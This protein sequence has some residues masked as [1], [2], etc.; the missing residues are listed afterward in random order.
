MKTKTVLSIASA[1]FLIASACNAGWL[2]QAYQGAFCA[3]DHRYVVSNDGAI[4]LQTKEYPTAYGMNG[5][6][7]EKQWT[8]D[9][10]FSDLSDLDNVISDLQKVS[11]EMHQKGG[12][13]DNGCN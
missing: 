5:A 10:T 6:Y 12:S 1:L 9:V 3:H 8:T 2:H 4:Y 13:C 11:K 7:P